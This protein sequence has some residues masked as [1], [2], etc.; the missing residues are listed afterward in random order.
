MSPLWRSERKP[1]RT[2][3]GGIGRAGSL[4]IMSVFAP[5]RA[6]SSRYSRMSCTGAFAKKLPKW[7]AKYKP[8]KLPGLAGLSA[9][10][11]RRSA[12]GGVGGVGGGGGGGGGGCGSV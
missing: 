10:A 8:R 7:V 1:A 9:A 5:H 6:M 2:L 12:E 3:R 4:M 11:H